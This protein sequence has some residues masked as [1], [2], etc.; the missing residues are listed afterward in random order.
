MLESKIV[1][2]TLKK[3]SDLLLRQIGL[4][5][6]LLI[7]LNVNQADTIETLFQHISNNITDTDRF[8]VASAFFLKKP[9]LSN[10]LGEGKE[11]YF[12]AKPLFRLDGFDCLSYVET[13]LAMALAKTP[14]AFYRLIR[15]LRYKNGNISYLERNHFLS[16]DWNRNNRAL[17]RDLTDTF[18]DTE[19]R[20]LAVEATASID[21]RAWFWHKTENDLIL[22]RSVN[23]HARLAQLKKMTYFFKPTEVTIRYLAL[24]ILFDAKANPNQKCFDH[25]PSGAIIE[26]IRPNWELKDKIGTNLHVSHLGLAFRKNLNAPLMFRH[27][28]SAQGR[29]VEVRLLDYLKKYLNHP[30][31]KGIK[32]LIP[33]KSA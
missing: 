3:G 16:L 33:Y 6:F 1:D 8:N 14:E 17:I 31:V 29:V 19:G 22:P 10:P 13:S 11:A 15:L 18:K 4:L 7:W 9:Y 32:V 30:T 26:I 25:I 24:T 12:I 5:G 21:K 27:A 20:M 2:L 28:S 23:K